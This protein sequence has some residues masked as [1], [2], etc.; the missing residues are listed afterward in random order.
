MKDIVLQQLITKEATYVGIF[1]TTENIKACFYWP[2]YEQNIQTWISSCQHARGVTP[3][4]LFLEHHWEQSKL[5][6]LLK[7]ALGT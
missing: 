5:V 2:G 3:H 6:T 1:K 4:N 7:N